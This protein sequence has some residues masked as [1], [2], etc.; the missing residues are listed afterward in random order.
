[1]IKRKSDIINLLQ[2]AKNIF[3]YD[4]NGEKYYFVFRD[5]ER[6]GQWTIMRYLDGHYTIHGKG[7]HY[8]DKEERALNEKSVVDMMW[9]KRKYINESLKEN[10]AVNA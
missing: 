10:E 7:E 5:D 2:N 9:R 3:S 8:C 4:E 1:M 6:G